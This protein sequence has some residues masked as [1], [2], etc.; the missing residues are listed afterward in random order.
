MKRTFPLVIVLMLLLQPLAVFALTSTEAKQDW[1]EA[2]QE[3]RQAQEAHRT[4]KI[5]WAS[6]KTQENN[7]QV[8]DTG[9]EALHA[10]LNEAEAWLIWRQLEIIENQEVPDELEQ[11]ILYDINVNLAKIDELR[12]EVDKAD[13]RVELALVFFKM[14]GKYLE[15]VVDVARNTGL[16]WVHIANTYAET[17]E[18]YEAQLREAAEQINNSDEIIEK[19]DQAHDE[20]ISAYDNI[21]DAETE[22]IQVTIPGN[23]LLSF[24][25]GNQHLRIAKNNL[26]AAHMNL[27][28]AYRLLVGAS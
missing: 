12:Q 16:V 23:P 27:K 18:D 9:K 25:N 15:L 17:I 13:N 22:Y 14:I 20:L 2:K 7:Q 1:R 26:V 10:A 3:S 24:A 19:L 11:T 5:Q 21:E 6:N 4:A 28:H 8:I